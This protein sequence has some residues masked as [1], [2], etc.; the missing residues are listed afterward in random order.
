MCESVHL[1]C[2]TCELILQMIVIHAT[3][4]HLIIKSNVFSLSLPSCQSSLYRRLH[5]IYF[6]S[7]TSPFDLWDI[8]PFFKLVLTSSEESLE[9]IKTINKN[10]YVYCRDGGIWNWIDVMC[11]S[12][13]VVLS[14]C[15]PTAVT[16]S[17]VHM[18]LTL[19]PRFELPVV[20]L[21]A[22]KSSQNVNL[23]LVNTLFIGSLKRK[24]RR[25]FGR[26]RSTR[27]G[28]CP[29]LGLPYSIYCICIS[30]CLC[31][32]LFALPFGVA[33]VKIHNT[34]LIR[35]NGMTL[36]LCHWLSSALH[37][38]ESQSQTPNPEQNWT[39]HFNCSRVHIFFLTLPNRLLNDILCL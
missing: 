5:C 17:H 24:R 18:V 8:F 11:A 21:L 19:P 27:I 9:K 3:L 38:K 39:D 2:F 37:S 16:L 32:C 35:S 7:F 33:A 34:T 4:I 23:S 12:F 20:S 26:I 29:I 22:N 13:R 10:E 30:M 31:L 6:V 15:W 1:F 14:H 25:T 28:T 36:T